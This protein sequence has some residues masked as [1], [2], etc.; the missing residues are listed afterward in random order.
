M[1]K[2]EIGIT[3]KGLK[4]LWLMNDEWN[5]HLRLKIDLE[6]KNFTLWQQGFVFSLS[7]VIPYL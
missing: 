7:F 6:I 5:D 4:F 1:Q 2:M 3:S